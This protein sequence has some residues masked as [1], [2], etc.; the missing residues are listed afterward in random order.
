VRAIYVSLLISG[1]G[2][3]MSDKL[4]SKSTHLLTAMMPKE[5]MEKIAM[6][7]LTPIDDKV[8]G[9]GTRQVLGWTVYVP[10]DF[11]W[12]ASPIDRP[13]GDT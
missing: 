4:V 6:L 10:D 2:Y 13:R 8:E 11:A 3:Y 5:I 9:V 1:D 12:D 7:N